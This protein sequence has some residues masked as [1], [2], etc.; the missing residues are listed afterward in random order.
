MYPG[1]YE[2][3]CSNVYCGPNAARECNGTYRVNPQCPVNVTNE[4]SLPDIPMLR[5]VNCEAFLS[6]QVDTDKV[7]AELCGACQEDDNGLT[8]ITCEPSEPV[9]V[10]C[11]GTK[12]V[13]ETTQELFDFSE[14]Q[15]IDTFCGTTTGGPVWCVTQRS[16]AQVDSFA[17]PSLFS[18]EATVEGV[19]CASCSMTDCGLGLDGLYTWTKVAPQADCTNVDQDSKFNVCDGTGTGVFTSLLVTCPGNKTAVAPLIGAPPPIGTPITIVAQPQAPTVI[20]PVLPP[21][22]APAASPSSPVAATKAPVAVSVPIVPMAAPVS[23]SAATVV[24]GYSH[25][26]HHHLFGRLLVGG[27]C[28][29]V[30]RLVTS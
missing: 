22:A 10:G 1:Q 21:T 16:P 6:T 14:H 7:L 30:F 29:L 15:F 13:C 5:N 3:D 25:Y 8:T 17:D 27:C 26:H 2:Y 9:C 20:A 12:T 11:N 23:S 4:A 24:A 28:S 18:C 19:A